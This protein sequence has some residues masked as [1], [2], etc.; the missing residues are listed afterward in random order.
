MKIMFIGLSG[1]DYPFTRVRC[2][3]FAKILKEYGIESEVLSF[4][5]HLAPEIE[6]SEIFDLEDG[7]KL[8][9]I[10]KAFWRLFREK[11][12]T[13]FYIQKIHYNA[14]APFLLHRLRKTKFILDYDDSRE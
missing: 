6:E 11:D 5:D 10:R 14:A 8:K 9:L 1:Y 12:D 2:Y 7:D 13:V 3:H 4:K